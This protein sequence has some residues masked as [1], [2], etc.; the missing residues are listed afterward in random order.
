MY[1]YESI[2]VFLIDDSDFIIPYKRHKAKYPY[3]YSGS[4]VCY[5]LV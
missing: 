4:D 3:S 5:W 2:C 1:D